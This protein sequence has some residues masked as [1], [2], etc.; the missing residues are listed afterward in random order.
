MNGLA[1][2][3]HPMEK[4][5]QVARPPLTLEEAVAMGK[6]ELQGVK[7]EGRD[8]A[9]CWRRRVRAGQ[10]NGVGTEPRQERLRW[11]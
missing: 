1:V 11:R 2:W 9:L 10:I 6:L 5:E 8:T 3:G 7:P 4:P